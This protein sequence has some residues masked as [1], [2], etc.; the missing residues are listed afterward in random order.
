VLADGAEWIDQMAAELS[1]GAT[2]ILDFYNVAVR[3]W[4]LANL[5]YGEGT[6]QARTS[7]E[8]KL[9]ALKAGQCEAV[10]RAIRQ[11][12][13]PKAEAQLRRHETLGYFR[14][15]RSAMAY[16]RFRAAGLPIGSG[17]IEDTCCVSRHREQK[18]LTTS[19]TV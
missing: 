14:W 1:V 12:R 15:H 3:L 2:R 19:R 4:Q 8:V 18:S 11:L 16:E 10:C 9:A 17:A 5:R 6:P 13:L 7:A